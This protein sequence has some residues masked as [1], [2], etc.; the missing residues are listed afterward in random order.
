[1][2][3]ESKIVLTSPYWYVLYDHNGTYLLLL[4]HFTHV[5]NGGGEAGVR[6]AEKDVGACLH[7]IFCIHK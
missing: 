2:F 1:M 7:V 3:L 6:G 4:P 5:T